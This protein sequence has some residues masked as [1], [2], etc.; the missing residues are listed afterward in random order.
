M[1]ILGCYYARSYR[2]FQI[3]HTRYCLTSIDS[4]MKLE[5]KPTKCIETIPVPSS[6]GAEVFM[7]VL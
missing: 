1:N 5:K 7:T 6:V 3:K 4:K 2:I